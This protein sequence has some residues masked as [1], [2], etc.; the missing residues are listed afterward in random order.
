[1]PVSNESCFNSSTIIHLSILPDGRV[2]SYRCVISSTGSE[3][4]A[5]VGTNSSVACELPG[6]GI[7]ITDAE[8]AARI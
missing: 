6:S 7:A 4:M 1:M 3:L 8:R 5:T 2:Y